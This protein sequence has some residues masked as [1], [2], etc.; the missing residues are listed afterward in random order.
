[1]GSDDEI[2]TFRIVK[3]DGVV[4]PE[5]RVGLKRAFP[6]SEDNWLRKLGEM[7]GSQFYP[8]SSSSTAWDKIIEH[9]NL[10]QTTNSS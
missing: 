2:S 1:M 10:R 3:S 9:T 8:K 5:D 7:L 6:S 4:F